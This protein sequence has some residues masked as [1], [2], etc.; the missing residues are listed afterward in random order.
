MGFAFTVFSTLVTHSSLPVFESNARKRRSLVAPMNTR[1]P[2]VTV[3]P[4]LPL[5]PTFC[6]P[7]GRKS[8]TPS[9]VCHAISPV[10]AL[11]AIKR[12]HGGRWHGRITSRPS[13]FFPADAENVWNG[14]TPSIDARSY[15]S[16]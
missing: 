10:L 11:T 13:A 2:A 7:A 12:D 15:S 3:G 16:V 8:L 6:L 1:P 9:V 5:P 14:P 4:A